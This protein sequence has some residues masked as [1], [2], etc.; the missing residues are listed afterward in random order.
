MT[1]ITDHSVPYAT[2]LETGQPSKGHWD[3][4][5]KRG[6]LR[7]P[8]VSSGL[9]LKTD[10]PAPWCSAPEVSVGMQRGWG[11]VCHMTAEI[12]LRGFWEEG[13]IGDHGTREA[14]V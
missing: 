7:I 9:Q 10:M 4:V 8:L 3:G 6:Q 11:W 14:S 5:G 2:V 1:S 13:N 12:E